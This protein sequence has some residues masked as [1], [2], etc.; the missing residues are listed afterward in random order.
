MTIFNA[1]YNLQQVSPQ[2]QALFQA[3]AA[4]YNI[5]QIIDEV[6]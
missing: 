5:R 1:V 6:N 3:Q 2:F 4:A